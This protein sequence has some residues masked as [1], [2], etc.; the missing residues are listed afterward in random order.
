[1]R[2]SIRLIYEIWLFRC[3]MPSNT[4]AKLPSGSK[5]LHYKM[6][7]NGE[8]VDS[9]GGELLNVI[10]PANERVIAKVPK[11]TRK[12]ARKALESAARAQPKW[13]EL[14]PVKRASYLFKIAE[15]DH[16]NGT[17][18]RVARRFCDDC[19]SRDQ[20]RCNLSC[21]CR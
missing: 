20:S 6:Y 7:I 3:D 15:L 19:I 11:G 13:E 1:M 12:D 10:N 2:V 5:V 9:E 4:S 21:N 18:R 14:A 8:W 16:L 17:E